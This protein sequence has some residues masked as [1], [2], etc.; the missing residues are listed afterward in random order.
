MIELEEL[1]T[2]QTNIIDLGT[3]KEEK[4]MLIAKMVFIF[5]DLSLF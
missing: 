2:N 4:V 5:T 3:G 1:C